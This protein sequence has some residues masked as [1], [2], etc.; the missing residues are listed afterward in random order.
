MGGGLAILYRQK[1]FKHMN[2]NTNFVFDVD[3]TLTPSRLRIDSLF[4][5]FFLDWMKEKKVYLLTGSDHLKTIEQLSY[6]IW[7]SVTESHQCGGNVVYSKGKIKKTCDWKPSA[8]LLNL[9]QDLIDASPYPIRA[10]NHL[11]VRDGLLNI[12]V[13]GRSCMQDQR[14]EYYEWDKDSEERLN[15]CEEIEKEFPN[16]EA[17]AGGQISID[18]HEKGKNKSQ[19]IE[20]LDGLIYFYGDKTMPGGNDYAIASQLH[21]PHKVFQVENW[22][23]TM[24]LLRRV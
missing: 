11:E 17:T 8:N 14:L 13:V 9:C 4:E 12:S 15:I 21:D 1:N 16:L 5:E 19:I 10:G 3:G 6:K 7:E 20:V 23:E 18:I 22:E 2:N 24:N